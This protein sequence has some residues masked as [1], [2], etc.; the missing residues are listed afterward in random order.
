MITVSEEKQTALDWIE[1]NWGI[2]SDFHQEIWHYAEPALREYKSA[3]AYIKLLREEGF[4]VEE[5][6]GGMPTAFLA[7]YGE[8]RPVLA[9]FAEYDA[10]PSNNQAATPYKKLRDGNLH[11][12]AA[13]HTD[14]HSSLG[15]TALAG[16]LGAKAAMQEHG[17]E[18]T[19]KFFGEPAEKICISKPYH[20]ARGYY[21]GLDACILYHPGN[22]NR[23]V[24]ETHCGSYW[25]VAYTFEAQEPENWS[26]PA[27]RVGWYRANPGAL[28]A[29]CMMYTMTKY[30]KEA[31]H[32]RTAGWTLT[33][34]ISIAGQSNTAPPMISQIT[35]AFRAPTLEMQ[36]KTH[37]FL[38]RNAEATAQACGCK[39]IERIVTK[40]R[41]GLFN[42]KM[43]ELVDRNLRLVGPTVYGEEAK[44][45]GREIQRNL[46]LEPME[47]PFTEDCQRLLTPQEGE[48]IL[49]RHLPD[50]M[51]H[52]SSDDYVEYMW[53]APT[54]RLYTAKATLRAVKDFRYPGWPRLAMTGERSTIESSILEGG[55][56]LAI[57]FVELLTEPG[58]LK[59]AWEEFNERTGG[60]IGGSKWVPPLL[61]ADL[62]PPIDMRWPEYVKTERGEEWWIPTPRKGQPQ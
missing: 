61:P 31:M 15:V 32:P 36:E 34:Y 50:W 46:G 60:G 4:T 28:D 40:T 3:K 8:G 42:R 58:L 35:Y 59:V 41:V 10:V 48:E 24:W 37:E 5:G 21:D 55:K 56:T 23:V 38:R 47:D 62:D 6:S 43:A 13:G 49:R 39:V 20:A 1:A 54:A 27:G 9:S 11:P 44:G 57:S 22:V 29:V 51:E 52:Y 53:H 19:L 12:Y 14:P 33:E 25:N 17:L 26:S 2:L 16:T 7:K 45:F 18:G 30:T